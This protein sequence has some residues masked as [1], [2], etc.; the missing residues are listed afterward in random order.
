MYNIYSAEKKQKELE[1]VIE[2]ERKINN[3]KSKSKGKI[4]RSI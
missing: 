2:E 4:I 1:K 3:V